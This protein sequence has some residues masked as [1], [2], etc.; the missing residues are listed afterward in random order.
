MKKDLPQISRSEY[1][2]RRK[3]LAKYCEKAGLK[4]ALVW[5]RH[6]AVSD[7]AGY[8][9]YLANYSTK[10]FSGLD[11]FSPYW[12]SR[13]HSAVV[14][15]CQGNATLI[16]DM[17]PYDSDRVA[18]AIGN[19]KHDYNIIRG[20][21]TALKESGLEKG[22]VG[23]IGTQ[24]V[25]MKHVQEIQ[26]ALPEVEWVPADD[27]LIDQMMIK[28]EAELSI[29]RYGCKAIADVSS[30]VLEAAQPGV[31]EM[32]LVN[33]LGAGLA[34]KGCELYWMRPNSPKRLKRGEI[35]YIAIVGC[36]Q[37]YFLD[38]SRNKVVGKKPN[39][40]QTEFLNL[41]SEF[42][43][44][45]AEELRPNRSAGDAAKFG[46]RYFIDE[47][48]EFS[49]EEFEAGILGT[50]AGFGHGLGLTFGRP[51]I[52]EGEEVMLRP[53]MYMAVEA[54][55]SKPGIG[56]AEA[57]VNLEITESGPRILTKL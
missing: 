34:N 4:G 36:C 47:R 13:G 9:I 20:I 56:M 16:K 7:R 23:L 26:H 31:S 41:L 51:F 35:Y 19:V 40:K 10:F 1:E 24:I 3:H 43:L 22:R 44:R 15:P 14:L 18:Q 48:K 30:Q 52:R 27:L 49:R 42:V 37:G 12:A 25:S 39:A 50:F 46:L 5:S 29:I 8:S 28:T 45:Q 57:E 55:Y 17:I 6:G 2:E 53:G 33:Q 21:V 54:V 32:E 38:I 11:D